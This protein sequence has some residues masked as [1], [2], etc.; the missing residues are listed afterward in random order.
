MA[1]RMGIGGQGQLLTWKSSS[2][3]KHNRAG[4]QGTARVRRQTAGGRANQSAGKLEGLSDASRAT[5]AAAAAASLSAVQLAACMWE[6]AQAPQPL[7]ASQRVTVG[8]IVIQ[9]D[10]GGAP[11]VRLQHTA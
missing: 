2:T 4:R 1:Q 10:N 7:T 5:A 8:L 11:A 6:A 3:A 9:R